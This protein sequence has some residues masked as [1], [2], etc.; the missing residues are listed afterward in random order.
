MRS[1]FN[2][3]RPVSPQE[4]AEVKAKYGRRARCLAGG[5]DLMLQCRHGIFNSE[6]CLDLTYIPELNYIRVG[7]N[8]LKIGP[9]TTLNQLENLK[10]E[11]SLISSIRGTVSQMC[12]PQLRNLATIGGNLCNASP[13]ADLSTL[14]IA[15]N[16]T[17]KILSSSGERSLPLEDFFTGV[18]KTA[19]EEDEFLSGIQIPIPALRTGH[20]FSRIGRT[21]IDIAQVNAAVSLSV[22]ENGIIV[23]PRIV[24][25]AVAP[26]PIRSSAAEKALSGIEISRVDDNLIQEAGK[27]AAADAR[28]VSDIRAAAD[29]RKYVCGILARRSI[30]ESILKLNGAIS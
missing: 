11:D 14:L 20:S 1:K 15:L 9:L 30:E 19:L 27:L 7:S 26:T 5:T 3:L 12:T 22:D 8:D 2:Y 25:G 10:E 17:G 24:L 4:A 16:A 6:Y 21:V 13:A 28:P 29:Y 18:N 23:D